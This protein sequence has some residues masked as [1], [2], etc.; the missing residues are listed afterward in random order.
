MIIS[1]SRRTDIPAYY[2]E[3]FCNR[4]DAGYCCVP[5][6]FNP[7]QISRI[8]LKVEDVDA[9]VFW[10]R[11]PGPLL[12][13]LPEL[14]DKG[15]RYYFLFTLVNN[16]Q[17]ID[18][19]SPPLEKAVDSFHRLADMIGAERVIWRYDPIVL[20]NK[21]PRSYHVENYGRIAEMLSGSTHRSIIS[22]MESY[23]KT[24]G[25]IQELYRRGIEVFPSEQLR[26]EDIYDFIPQLAKAAKKSGMVLQSCAQTLDMAGLGVS[27]GKCVDDDLISRLFHISV[28]S[29]KDASQ[30]KACMCAVSRDI[31]MYD[32]CLFGCSYCY[33]TKSAALA[34]RNHRQHNPSSPSLIG[35]HEK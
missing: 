24:A 8:S 1:A 5:N 31:G 23:R 12:P 20:S 30:R 29:R 25:R 14:T 35:W 7:R 2:P 34:L 28:P 17:A 9:I 21:T 15:Y 32:S 27:P 16:P 19:A 18:P 6:P 22:F 10:T 4:I 33:A 11:Y 13:R 26:L 3:W